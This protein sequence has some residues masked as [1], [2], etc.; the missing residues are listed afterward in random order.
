M[1][2]SSSATSSEPSLITWCNRHFNVDNEFFSGSP[3][4]TETLVAGS[5]GGQE[6]NSNTPGV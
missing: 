5:E 4:D 1:L 6:S 3:F 2:T